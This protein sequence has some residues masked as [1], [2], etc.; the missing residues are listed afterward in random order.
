MKSSDRFG[1]GECVAAGL[2][3]AAVAVR[4]G[5]VWARGEDTVSEVDVERGVL[6]PPL[7][8]VGGALAGLTLSL[9]RERVARVS[10]SNAGGEGRAWKMA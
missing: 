4:A 5:C 7:P 6:A 10:P 1:R 2:R 8:A 9:R 3:V